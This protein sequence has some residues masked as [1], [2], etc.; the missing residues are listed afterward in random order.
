MCVRRHTVECHAASLSPAIRDTTDEYGEYRKPGAGTTHNRMCEIWKDQILRKRMAKWW[1]EYGGRS[2]VKNVDQRTSSYRFVGWMSLA[3]G[4]TAW[5]PYLTLQLVV[6]VCREGRLPLLS[7]TMKRCSKLLE[8]VA[9]LPCEDI[10]GHP[11][12]IL[13]LGTGN[14]KPK[15]LPVRTHCKTCL[16]WGSRG[17]NAFNC[18]SGW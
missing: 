11:Q 8:R 6:G 18:D 5:G 7:Y 16:W 17:E 1:G 3:M 13:W 9:I 2:R 14:P 10:V 15:V 12:Y 4:C